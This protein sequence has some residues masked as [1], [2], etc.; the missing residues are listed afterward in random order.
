MSDPEKP[1]DRPEKKA[2]K[3]GTA[4]LAAVQAVYQMDIAGTTVASLLAEFEAHRLGQTVDGDDYRQADVLFFKNI[5][6]GV[7]EYQR[8]IDVEINETLPANWPLKRIDV[9][10]RSILRCGLYEMKYRQDVAA[11]VI[12]SEYLD[13]TDAFYGDDEMHL[14]NG[15]LDRAAKTHR[16]NE[17]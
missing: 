1:A 5:V 17:L 10:L 13:V 3:R 6:N 12:I 11:K 2:N 4:R 14:L 15:M 8:D 16:K 9:T 7:L